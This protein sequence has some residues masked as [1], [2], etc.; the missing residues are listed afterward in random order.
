MADDAAATTVDRFGVAEPPAADPVKNWPSCSYIVTLT[1]D[2]LLTTG[3]SVPD[4]V[5]DQ[6][7]FHKM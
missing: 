6:L 4:P 3:D 2:V 7:A 1:V 5:L